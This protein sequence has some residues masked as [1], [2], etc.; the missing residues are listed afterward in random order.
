MLLPPIVLSAPDADS[1]VVGDI[2]IRPD[3]TLT[4]KYLQAFSRYF[5]LFHRVFGGSRG[6]ISES[7]V[8]CSIQLS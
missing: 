2:E 3:S 4:C 1:L 5:T 7:V 6:G 8:R